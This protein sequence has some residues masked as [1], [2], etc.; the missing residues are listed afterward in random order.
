MEETHSQADRELK[1]LIQITDS[2]ALES[3]V[4]DV[5]ADNPKAVADYNSGENK[6][7]GFL[8]GQVMAATQGKADPRAVNDL[9]RARL[10]G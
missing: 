3:A 5:I 2:S 10:D 7:V 8:V 4:D 1:R 6:I 9:I